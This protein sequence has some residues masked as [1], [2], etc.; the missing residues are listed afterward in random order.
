LHV[1]TS[2]KEEYSIYYYYSIVYNVLSAGCFSD[3][4]AEEQEFEVVGD[5]AELKDKVAKD[6]EIQNTSLNGDG[7]ANSMYFIH[8]FL[9]TLYNRLIVFS[10]VFISL[11]KKNSVFFIY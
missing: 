10:Q 4:L 3:R 7:H 6:T 11:I 1:C 2:Q 8:G 5:I 9:C